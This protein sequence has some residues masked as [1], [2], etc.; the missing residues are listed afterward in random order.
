VVS[1]GWTYYQSIWRLKI[2]RG[3]TAR[4]GETEGKVGTAHPTSGQVKGKVGTAH[5][6]LQ[7][8][9]RYR[10]ADEGG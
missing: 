5:P 6:Q 3:G 10:L 9:V 1:G 7:D 8:Q 2:A 4:T